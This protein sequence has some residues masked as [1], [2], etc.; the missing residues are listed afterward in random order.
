MFALVNEGANILSEGIAQ[1]ASDIDVIYAFGYG[2]PRYRGGP[3]FYANTIG[4]EKVAEGI[5][6]FAAGSLGSHWAVSPHL[7]KLIED[8]KIFGD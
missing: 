1:R 7:L 4:L 8:Q 2:F 6:G 5:R 3:M